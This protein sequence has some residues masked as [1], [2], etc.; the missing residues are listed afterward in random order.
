MIKLPEIITEEELF[1][2]LKATKKPEHRAA[3]VF[4]FYGAMRVSEV[5]K[6][7]QEDID[8]VVKLIWIKQGKGHKDRKIPLTPEMMKYFKF[9]PVNCGVRALQLT[10]KGKG[11]KALNRDLHFHIL[12]HSGITHYITIK[13]WSTLE[14]Q[15]LAGHSKSSITEIYTH[16]SPLDLVERAWNNK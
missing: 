3:F 10:F 11:K 12:R 8:K 6:L 1:E 15:R 5:V 16:I 13:K 2:I 14:V 4:G 9:I 7:K